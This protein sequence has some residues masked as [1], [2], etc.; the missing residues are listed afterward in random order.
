[1][2][3]RSMAMAGAALVA[4]AAAKAATPVGPEAGLNSFATAV[5][6]ALA[7]RGDGN[8]FFSPYS[9]HAALT[10]TATGARG[11]TERQ[12][13]T[14][15]GGGDTAE[16]RG[17]M[18][19]R[20]ADSLRTA[21]SG[22]DIALHLANRVW[23]QQDVKVLAEFQHALRTQ[24]A[25]EL[26]PADLR[27]K[28]ETVRMDINR[29]VED[30]TKNKI[31]DLIP[32]GA[33]TP[34]MKMVLA[35]AIY[36]YGAWAEAFEPS[37]TKAAPFLAAD[38]KAAPVPLMN[39]RLE[40]LR[41]AEVEGVQCVDL[42]YKGN[43]LAL[44]LLLPRAGELAALEKKLKSGGLAPFLAGR[45]TRD[46]DLWLPRFKS[47]ESFEL[48]KTLA[49]LGAR[50]AFTDAA[51]FSGITGGR[52]LLISSVIHKAI[53]EVNEKGTEAAAA[54]A[55]LMRPTSIAIK[56]PPVQFRADHPFVY[57]IL[58]RGSGAVLFMG[59]LVRPAAN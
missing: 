15:L 57:T 51:D 16:A 31:V 59:R 41:Y 25:S 8:V 21:Q 28:A 40:N 33:L 49:A 29:W 30:Q 32:A 5:Y 20:L 17:A 58:D 1:M 14:L 53:I 24:F 39:A 11:E 13:A 38:G 42:P 45:R 50:D 2:S 22:G 26:V 10:M 35:N 27:G 56:D 48:A 46:V 12:L 36:F 9:V 55:V 23:V 37:R 7:E 52:D 6:A 18:A 47:S 3:T 44:V 43:R 54:T 34:D 4:V 19:K